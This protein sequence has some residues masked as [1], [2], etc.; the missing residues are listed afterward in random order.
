VSG[1]S[2]VKVEWRTSVIE[3]CDGIYGYIGDYLFFT[4][5][6]PI[7]NLNNKS[8]F[9]SS[10]LPGHRWAGD[11]VSSNSIKEL[12]SKAQELFDKFIKSMI[13]IEVDIN[14][15]VPERS[16]EEIIKDY[17]EVMEILNET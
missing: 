14:L 16:D 5:D 2:V 9:L 11:T 3:C 17:N 10:N 13:V 8:H 15:D 12:Q 4:I 6:K 7:L 1:Y